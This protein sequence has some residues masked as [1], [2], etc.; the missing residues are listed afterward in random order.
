MSV[1]ELKVERHG[2]VAIATITRHAR[3]N[4]LSDQLV[5]ELRKALLDHDAD[6]TVAATVIAG[7]APGFSAGS[8]LKE[9]SAMTLDEMCTHEART[10]AFCREIATLR[11]PV[12]AAVE[13]FALGGGF[14]LACSCDVVV[15]GRSTRWSLP[16]VAIGWIPPWGIETLINRAGLAKARQLVWGGKTIQGDEAARLGVAD[17]AVDD[18][19]AVEFAIELANSLAK[20]PPESV[21]STKLYFATKAA[22]DGEGGDLL[23]S[24]LFR[25]DCRNPV[26]QATLKRFGVKA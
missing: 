21:A 14:V 5:A 8:D 13:G 9:L 18:G 17:H 16:E 2:P 4:A 7:T 6:S 15:T 22:R 25:E 20:L 3:R 11:K 24:R 12:L 1:N 23:A 19:Q 26:A 10:A